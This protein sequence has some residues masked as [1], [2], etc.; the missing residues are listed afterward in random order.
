MSS[1]EIS[2]A[3]IPRTDVV[4]L[5][6]T[7]VSYDNA[8]ER[9]A[10][11]NRERVTVPGRCLEDYDLQTVSNHPRTGEPQVVLTQYTAG[12]M[13]GALVSAVRLILEADRGRK[14]NQ[15]V[16][17]DSLQKVFLPLPPIEAIVRNFSQVNPLTYPGSRK[18]ITRSFYQAQEMFERI[19]DWMAECQTRAN[20]LEAAGFDSGWDWRSALM[21][22]KIPP[23]DSPLR[24]QTQEVTEETYDPRLPGFDPRL[25]EGPAPS[26]DTTAVV[27]HPTASHYAQHVP[28]FDPFSGEPQPILIGCSGRET[29]SG[30]VEIAAAED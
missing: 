13:W 26:F 15:L 5:P 30:D 17:E 7:A 29:C 19:T 27:L 2:T 12:A 3:L 21:A 28:D 4:T 23:P 24:F 9:I 22:H 11:A 6:D 8:I 14:E 25:I 16:S 1:N 10:Q 20:Q 18:E